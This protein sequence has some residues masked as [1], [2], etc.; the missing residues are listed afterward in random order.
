MGG[1]ADAN[2]DLICR[3]LAEV[4]RGNADVVET[5][6]APDYVDHTPSPIRR[7]APGREGVRQALAIFRRAFPD[8]RHTIEDLVA[9][10]DRVVVRLSARGTHTGEFIGVAPTGEVVTMTGIAIYRIVDG[11]I[12]ERWAEQSL[13][14]LEQ[15]G[16]AAPA[17]T[18]LS[19]ADRHEHETR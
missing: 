9:E 10:E 17:P 1:A 5:Y 19:G 2:K 8:T 6:Y 11:R 12:A 15:L 18:S 3:L 7:L 14:V 16:I 13:G 4:D